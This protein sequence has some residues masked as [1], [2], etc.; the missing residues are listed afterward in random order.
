MRRSLL[1][2]LFLVLILG[3]A[4]SAQDASEALALD[5]IETLP[6]AGSKM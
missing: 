5:V 1:F 3:G 2:L 6:S 4:V